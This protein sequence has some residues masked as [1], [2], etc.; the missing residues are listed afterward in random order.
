MRS[1]FILTFFLFLNFITSLSA[2]KKFD[3]T[4]KC[5]NSDPDIY[6]K[7]AKS[8]LNRGISIMSSDRDIGFIQSDWKQNKDNLLARTEVSYLFNIHQSSFEAYIY[9]QVDVADWL[10]TA[11]TPGHSRMGYRP[12]KSSH[13]YNA[14]Q[15]L[16]SIVESAGGCDSWNWYVYDENK[17]AQLENNLS[18]TEDN[19][20]ENNP[21]NDKLLL[22]QVTI[23]KTS[24]SKQD[25]TIAE[26]RKEVEAQARNNDL[27]LKENGDL[28]SKYAL[29]DQ[30]HN[31]LVLNS[32][33]VKQE[34]QDLVRKMQSTSAPI[35]E[36][37]SPPT[38]VVKKVSSSE[39]TTI[40]TYER[41]AEEYFIQFFTSSYSN[42]T[43]PNLRGI[44]R[45]VS[46]PKGN[47]TVYQLVVD[48]RSKVDM[49]RSRGFKDAFVVE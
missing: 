24:L 7:I 2:Q 34:K 8:M 23:L 11:E 22:D 21:E 40:T 15:T 19:S 10:S 9:A 6:Q 37:T 1:L 44:G 49:V 4:L 39:S 12:L 46:L 38:P 17:S 31:E 42:K 45:L 25:E 5:A 43:F 32:Q 26:L 28:K 35:P 48:D 3:N 41:K 16:I 27:L 18:N 29:L 13:A 47:L 36:P 30:R 14:Y 33:K 20:I